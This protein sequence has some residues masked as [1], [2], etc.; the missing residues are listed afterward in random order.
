MPRDEQTV[1]RHVRNERI[2][3]LARQRKSSR[4]IAREVGISHV[5]VCEVIK[6][7]RNPDYRRPRYDTDDDSITA[8]WA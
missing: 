1:P 8:F 2:I 5:M 3:A 4:E 7:W 6:K